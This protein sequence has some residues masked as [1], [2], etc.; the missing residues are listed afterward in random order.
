MGVGGGVVQ[1]V[2]HNKKAHKYHITL[3][4]TL[5]QTWVAPLQTGSLLFFEYKIAHIIA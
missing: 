1:T 2:V 3:S 5:L 4:V